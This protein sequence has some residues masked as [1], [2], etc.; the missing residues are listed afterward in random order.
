MV[1]ECPSDREMLA[2]GSCLIESGDSTIG[3]VAELA[4]ILLQEAEYAP[5]LLEEEGRTILSWLVYAEEDGLE[6]GAIRERLEL[7]L[8]NG[9]P[10]EPL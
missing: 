8:E 2:V 3:R 5:E 7:A 9:T 4:E 6:V 10:F 1:L